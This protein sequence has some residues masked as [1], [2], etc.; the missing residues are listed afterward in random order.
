[1]KPSTMPDHVGDV[2]AECNR[3]GEEFYV[4]LD[5]DPV[6]CAEC[7]YDVASE[8]RDAYNNLREGVIE[9]IKD[10]DQTRDTLK[11]LLDDTE[12]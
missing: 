1:M 9:F 12:I 10:D 2:T 6:A 11:F 3:C 5:T 4:S 7:I 8:Y